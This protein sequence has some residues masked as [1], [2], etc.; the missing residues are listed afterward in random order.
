MKKKLMAAVL[1]LTLLAVFLGG[2]SQKKTYYVPTKAEA[3]RGYYF[4]S[5]LKWEGNTLKTYRKYSEADTDLVL[6]SVE[7]F[8]DLGFVVK[9]ET[10]NKEGKSRGC[11]TYTYTFD[12]RGEIADMKADH[13]MPTKDGDYQYDKQVICEKTYDEKGDIL[14]KK[15]TWDDSYGYLLTYKYDGDGRVIEC[16]TRHFPEMEC[17]INWTQRTYEY[18]AAGKIVKVAGNSSGIMDETT[19]EYD[20]KGNLIKTE[21]EDWQHTL[22]GYVKATEAQYNYWMKALNGSY[23]MSEYSLLY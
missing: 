15:Y 13:V 19:Y 11:V 12:E 8:N 20:K 17:V 4:C 3:V 10:F 6:E 9:K 1:A 5:E 7:E 18:D 22:S 14:T 2:C 16:E 21:S 23:G